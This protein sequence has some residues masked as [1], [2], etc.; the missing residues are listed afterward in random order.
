MA[1]DDDVIFIWSFVKICQL[2]GKLL[3]DDTHKHGDTISIHLPWGILK[4]FHKFC[5]DFW[6]FPWLLHDLPSS[7]SLMLLSCYPN[8]LCWRVQIMNLFVM[9]LSPTFWHFLH[10]KS[11]YFSHYP[12]IKNL[13]SMFFSEC[14]RKFHTCTKLQ[15]NL[16]LKMWL[17]EYKLQ[18]L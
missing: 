12:V 1:F 13:K 4:Y 8:V 16:N 6:S 18:T 9:Q 14:K 15:E 3:R 17:V 2:A 7:S 11:K 5:T 10:P